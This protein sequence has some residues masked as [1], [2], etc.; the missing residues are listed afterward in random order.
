MPQLRNEACH[1]QLCC[2]AIHC[3]WDSSHWL[4]TTPAT[5]GWRQAAGEAFTLRLE[6][7]LARPQRTLSWFV[8]KVMNRDPSTSM[9]RTFCA[10]EECLHSDDLIASSQEKRKP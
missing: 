8:L 5:L 3:C 4:Y 7:F 6:N 2:I 10:V 9:A 1:A